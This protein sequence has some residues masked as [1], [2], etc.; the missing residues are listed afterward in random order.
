MRIHKKNK[1]LDG[2]PKLKQE[3]LDRLM[4]LLRDECG[5]CNSKRW[6]FECNT[7]IMDKPYLEYRCTACGES[8]RKIS[9]D[10]I[11]TGKINI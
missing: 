8:V 1:I 10:Y 9:L 2:V 3:Q 4:G 5:V 6:L 7:E 11:K